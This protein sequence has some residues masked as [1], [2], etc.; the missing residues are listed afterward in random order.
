MPGNVFMLT[1]YLISC[2]PDYN[3]LTWILFSLRM[4]WSHCS[5]VLQLLVLLLRLLI[6]GAYSYFTEIVL[7][8]GSG[9][10]MGGF[11]SSDTVSIFWRIPNSV[12]KH[13]LCLAAFPAWNPPFS[14]SGEYKPG[15]QYPGSQMGTGARKGIS[16]ISV[17]F[18]LTPCFHQSPSQ[19]FWHLQDHIPLV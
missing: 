7:L 15:C 13:V 4:F 14:F 12:S 9:L 5:I 1:S 11:Y 3:I 2:F 6:L 10:T 16:Q 18:H 8:V 19:L 17:N